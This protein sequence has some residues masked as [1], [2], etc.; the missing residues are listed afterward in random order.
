MS[1]N[2]M[3]FDAINRGD[4][5]DAREALARGA[6]L[7][8]HNVLGMTPVDLSVDLSRNDIT[9][10]LLSLRGAS[11]A[12]APRPPPPDRRRRQPLSR[13]KRRQPRTACRRA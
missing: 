9:F 3:L 8:A 4:A 2:D 10:L 1:P 5:G 6:D 11:R 12:D 13:R 7:G